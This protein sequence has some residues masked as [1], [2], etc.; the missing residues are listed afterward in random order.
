MTVEDIKWI[1]DQG[2][3]TKKGVIL[4]GGRYDDRS[5]E[6]REYSHGCLAINRW[7]LRC[8]QN[9]SPHFVATVSVG[10]L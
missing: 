3:W 6:S 1:E 5:E 8:A 2:S 4:N 9:D 10:Q 7:I